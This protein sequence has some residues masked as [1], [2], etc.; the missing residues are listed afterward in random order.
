M[1]LAAIIYFACALAASLCAFLLLH[2]FQ[3]GR[4]RLLLWSGLCFTGLAVN[5]F[6][7]VLDKLI[8]TMVDLSTVRHSLA[9]VAMVTL[10]Y[11]LI[12]EAE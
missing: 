12:M 2:S 9:L 10:L 1:N 7:L 4:Y 11:G 5:N 6:L 8:F 3:R